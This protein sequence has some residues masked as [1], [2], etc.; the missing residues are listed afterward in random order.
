MMKVLE[1]CNNDGELVI[2]ADNDEDKYY[3][4]VLSIQFDDSVDRVVDLLIFVVN[5]VSQSNSVDECLKHEL[6]KRTSF[7]DTLLHKYDIDE[8]KHDI[9][10]NDLIEHLESKINKVKDIRKVEYKMKA[11]EIEFTS[12]QVEH[13]KRNR[14][15]V[16]KLSDEQKKEYKEDLFLVTKNILGDYHKELNNELI[17]LVSHNNK[18]LISRDVINK[19]YKYDIT[20]SGYVVDEI[21]VI[22]MLIQQIIYILNSTS[23]KRGELQ[24]Y[25]EIELNN[26]F[27]TAVALY[28][29]IP[30]FIKVR[31]TM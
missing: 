30:N 27:E 22:N 10:V 17:K 29:R 23:Y 14:A 5:R 6:N 16:Y 28:E 11:T 21:N 13:D 4:N 31:H 12:E 7:I 18:S 19:Y 20:H 26:R 2:I 3:T 24:I 9:D 1:R 15:W 8:F 25:D